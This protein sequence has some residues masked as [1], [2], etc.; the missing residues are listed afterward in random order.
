VEFTLLAAAATSLAAGYATIRLLRVTIPDRPFDRMVGAALAGMFAGRLATML[1]AGINP[2]L[3][4]AEVVMVRGGVDTV[5]AAVVAAMTVAWPLRHRLPHLDH[6]AAPV[7]AALAGW[8]AGCLWRG[9]CLGTVTG[10]DWGWALPGSTVT[11]HPVEIYAAVL[12]AV[13]A[14]V[15]ARRRWPPL[16]ATG[17]AI[18]WAAGTRLLTQ[19]WRPSLDGGPRWFYAVGIVAGLAVMAAGRW[20]PDLD[21]PHRDRP[22]RPFRPAGDGR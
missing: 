16:A 15:V 19:I 9:T 11:R 2:L 10:L 1:G 3:H 5:W 14:L 6:L 22:S 13:G 8:H 4:P 12:F 18:A 7:L 21:L 20:L 17:A